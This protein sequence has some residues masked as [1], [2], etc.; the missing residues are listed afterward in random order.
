[1]KNLGFLGLIVAVLLGGCVGVPYYDA[2]QQYPYQVAPPVQYAPP[3]VMYVPRP[4]VVMYVPPM[5]GGYY[6]PP[7]YYGEPLF[8]FRF[9]FGKSGKHHGGG[10]HY[11]GR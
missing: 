5:Y 10:R 11:R 8:S 9:N 6:G 2:Y 4:P 1:M 3:Q 7:M